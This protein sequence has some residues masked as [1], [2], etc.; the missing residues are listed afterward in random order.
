MGLVEVQRLARGDRPHASHWPLG[1]GEP[2]LFDVRAEAINPADP[3][4][5]YSGCGRVWPE[6]I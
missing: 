6:F 4:G 1:K 2:D 5:N 3:V